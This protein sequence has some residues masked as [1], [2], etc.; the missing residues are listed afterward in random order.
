MTIQVGYGIKS[1]YVRNKVRGEVGLSTE[2]VRL[3]CAVKTS[4]V[5]GKVG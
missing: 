5:L 2:S 1:V 4:K 3:E